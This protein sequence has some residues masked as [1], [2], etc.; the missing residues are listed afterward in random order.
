MQNYPQDYDGII[1]GAAGPKTPEMTVRRMW[2]LLLRD[3]NPGLMTPADWRLIADSG[4]RTCDAAD[5]VVDGVA[6][7]PRACRFSIASLRCSGEKNATCLT[8]A[9]VTFAEKFYQPLVDA[10][11]RAIDDGLLAGVVVDS[12]R[13]RLAPATFGQ[14]VRRLADWNGEGF[15]VTTD[16]AALHRAMP[17]L[18]A[19][20]ADLSAFKARGG[21][22][23]LYQ[24]WMDPAVAGKMAVEYHEAVTKT[25]GGPAATDDFIRLFMVPGML[26][27]SGGPAPDQFG[28]SGRGDA[29]IVDARHDLLSALEAWVERGQAPTEIVAT[30]LTNGVATRTRPLCPYPAIAKYSGNGSTDDASSFRCVRP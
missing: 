22:A 1:A 16:L 20:K 30:R 4:T 7:D 9:Q 2:E 15:D 14:A 13:S 26:H 10:N 8:D 21:K 19:D 28:A 18:R 11:G 27:C 3:A 17:E 5:G 6:E 25:M 23:I 29:P 24:G 12:G